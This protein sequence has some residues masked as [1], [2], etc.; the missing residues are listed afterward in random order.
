MAIGPIPVGNAGPL[1]DVRNLVKH[2]PG[3]RR[4]LFGAPS[5]IRAVDDVGFTL[6]RGE[7]LGVVGESGSGKTTLARTLLRLH[8]ATSGQAFFDGEDIL[9]ADPAALKRLRRR[10]QVVFQDPYLAFNP[11]FTIGETIAEA[12]RIHFDALPRSQWAKRIGE[13][14]EQ[15]GL[16][17]DYAGR[18]PHEF[19]G[20]QRQ[21]VGIARALALE[22]DLVICDEPVSA[23]DV[24]VQAQVVNLLVDI[25]K[26]RKLSLIFVAH[27]LA[28]VRHISTRVAVMYLGKIVEIG[29]TDAVFERANHPYTQ[30]LLSAVPVPDPRG[31]EQR[32]RIVLQ[33]DPP[34]PASP[35][36]GCRF[37]TRCWKA[38][39][40]C[41]REEPALLD[42]RGTGTLSR[43]LFPEAG[44]TTRLPHGQ[45]TRGQE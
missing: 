11:R 15:V 7:T 14:L 16:R 19:S 12:W 35:P 21:R 37:R 42:R 9:T 36:S 24:S 27:D 25:Q 23:L 45:L 40:I 2:F 29:P 31:R 32:R 17:A 18:H 4:G 8:P 10:M 34:N 41:A 39:D 3:R 43:C 26:M 6:S 5:A 33:G 28:V 22:P 30:A 44:P 38:Q 20:G 1:L 13:L